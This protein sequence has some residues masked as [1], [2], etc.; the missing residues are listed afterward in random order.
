MAKKGKVQ[1]DNTQFL[2]A[3]SSRADKYYAP[4]QEATISEE[5]LS[6]LKSAFTNQLS[7]EVWTNV[8]EQYPD[9]KGTAEFLVSPVMQTGMKDD[10]K[11]VHGFTK[12][13][14][15]FTFD[16]GLADKQAPF[17]SAVRPLVCALQSLEMVGGVDDDGEEIP[18]PDPDHIKAL[19]EDAIVLLGNPHCRL[20]SWRQRRFAEFQTDVGKRTLKD[21]IPADKHLFPEQFHNVIREE[22]DHANT[23]R[24]VVAQPVSAHKRFFP[25]QRGKFQS[26][27][28]FR[29]QSY[30]R[31]TFVRQQKNDSFGKNP[32]N[33][34]SWS[35]RGGYSKHKGS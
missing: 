32:N 6:F 31:S 17:I 22:H 21:Q 28:S 16:D 14:D 12:T 1:D 24:K 20:N 3:T 35:R 11:R 2:S 4:V 34:S 25:G 9:I 30:R 26:N 7:K 19:I 29:N 15:V 5:L 10:I 8:M 23:N 18:G 13:K 33:R 27:N